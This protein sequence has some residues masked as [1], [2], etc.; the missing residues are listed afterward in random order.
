MADEFS[1]PCWEEQDVEVAQPEP[2]HLGE[3]ESEG[4]EIKRGGNC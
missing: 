4:W 1:Q 3:S 2:I